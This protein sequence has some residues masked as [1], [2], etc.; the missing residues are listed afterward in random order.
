[1]T[2]PQAIE[3]LKEYNEWRRGADTTQIEPRVIG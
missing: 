3:V 2:L 1:M